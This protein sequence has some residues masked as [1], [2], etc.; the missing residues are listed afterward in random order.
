MESSLVEIYSG[1][2]WEVE[3]VKTLLEN[4]EIKPFLRDE[5]SGTIAPWNTAGGG[6]G[7]IKVD[8]PSEDY[9]KAI[10]IVQEFENN[11]KQPF[12]L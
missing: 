1:N 4:A 2:T 3:I 5:F 12:S 9:D 7:A 6:A 10:L 8:V 11:K